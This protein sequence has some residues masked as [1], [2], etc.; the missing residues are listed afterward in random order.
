MKS[1]A[2]TLL[3]LT[4]VI[5]IIGIL[6]IIAIPNYSK[7]MERSRAAE[8]VSILGA[9][10]AAQLRYFDEFDVY[11]NGTEGDISMLDVSITTP[12]F[13]N[14]LTAC[15][16]SG[17]VAYVDRNNVNRLPFYGQYRLYIYDD[18]RIVCSNASQDICAALSLPYEP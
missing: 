4:I 8:G 2:F 18:G 6:A 17:K 7:T 5:V 16:D 9:L 1:K 14:T 11:A 13:F 12:K 10:R 3:E 15:N